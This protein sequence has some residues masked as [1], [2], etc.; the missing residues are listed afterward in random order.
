MSAGAILGARSRVLLTPRLR[1]TWSWDFRRGTIPPSAI[2]SGN[3]GKG[4]VFTPAGMLVQ[5]TNN[6]P[7]FDHDPVTG[8]PWGY[9]SEMGSTNA[10]T[11][12]QSIAAHW[13]AG[14]HATITDDA[15]AAPDGTMTATSFIE[16][17]A[18]AVHGDW[19]LNITVVNGGVYGYSAF[20]KNING[21]RWLQLSLGGGSY[22]NFRASDGA[23]GSTSANVATAASRYLGN[24][25]FRVSALFTATATTT[26]SLRL[27]MA[28][29]SNSGGGPS[30]AGDGASGFAVWGIQFETAGIGVTSYIPTA[31]SVATRTQDMLTLLLSSLSGWSV[32]QGGALATA[33]RLHGN[34]TADYQHACSLNDGGPNNAIKV[35]AQR[36]ANNRRGYTVTS[37]GLHQFDQDTDIPPA[38]F[39]RSKLATGWSS[40]RAI[41]CA[42]GA[43]LGAL[44]QASSLPLTLTNLGFGMFVPA[45]TGQLNGTL[46]SIAYYRGVRPDAFVQAASL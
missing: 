19:E 45:S 5:P 24:G 17:A 4:G 7:R 43:A 33:Y 23:I 3:G 28:S 35:R 11:W 2:Y 22:V 44:T 30:Y 6:S 8:V 12:S 21:A 46:E 41:Q 27:Y 25:W 14:T 16:D 38:S 9:L 40:I 26:T 39:A 32:A 15:I 29:A 42:D 18:T 13:T 36:V 10:C 37:N 20:I 34:S 1:P 31:G